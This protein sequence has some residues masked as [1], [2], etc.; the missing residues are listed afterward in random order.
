MQLPISI[1]QVWWCKTNQNI[2]ATIF[3]ISAYL[4]RLALNPLYELGLNVKNPFSFYGTYD[5]G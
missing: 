3:S 5:K 1:S 4:F 2:D